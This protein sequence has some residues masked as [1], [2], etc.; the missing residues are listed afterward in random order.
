[1]SKEKLIGYVD[2]KDKE[3]KKKFTASLYTKRILYRDSMIKSKAKY[4][5]KKD[6]SKIYEIILREVQ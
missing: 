1:M 4:W 3:F 2:L 6:G 5:S